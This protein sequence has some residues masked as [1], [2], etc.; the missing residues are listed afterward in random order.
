[1]LILE[2]SL[3]FGC[4]LWAAFFAGIE[5]GVISIN[6]LKL[7]HLAEEENDRQ[8]QLLE[9]F[10]ANP[11][12]LL[13]TTLVGVNICM[14]AVSVMGARLGHCLPGRGGE[15]LSEALTTLIV[16]ICCEYLPKAWFQS[17]PIARCRPFAGLLW[18]MSLLLKPLAD[19][20]TWI[21][22]FLLRGLPAGSDG[23]RP[24]V[25]REEIDILAKE[26]AEHGNLTPKQRIMIHRV[27][28]L[29][30]KNA[31]QVMGPRA[32][33]V[34]IDSHATA[35]DF[36]KLS[37]SSNFTRL[38]VFDQTRGVFIGIANL[39]D[40]LAAPAGRYGENITRFMR[41]PQ[42][43]RDTTPL[44]EVLPRLRRSRQPLAL[45]ANAQSE[46]VGFLTTEDVLRHVIGTDNASVPSDAVAGIR[47]PP[48]A[49]AAAPQH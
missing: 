45:V 6:H 41:P 3:F 4:L 8:A 48:P 30:G 22:M 10:L 13:G 7:R 49:A 44:T 25:T 24:V 35:E 15:V 16:L 33:M 39:F 32:R 27:V 37:C 20:F 21:T 28:E 14:V 19:F 42:F 18:T 1:M 2:I 17:N 9:R 5:T 23:Q 46:V 26:S 36:L 12:R 38:P 40:V 11:D 31:A 34:F 29:A 43:L 47:P